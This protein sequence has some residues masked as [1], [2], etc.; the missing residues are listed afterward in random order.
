MKLIPIKI[1]LLKQGDNAVEELITAVQDNGFNIR[2]GDIL[3]IADKI[4]A[5]CDGR[6]VNLKNVTPSRKAFE[7]AKK[8]QLE[9][10]FVEL[11][12]KEA[13]EIYGGVPR[14][15][16]TL[17][18]N[19]LIANAG[20]DHKNVPHG[21]AALWPLNPN[22]SAKTLY[23]EIKKKTGKKIG[24]IL[25]DSHVNPLRMGTTGF[26]LGLA[27]FNPIKDCRGKLDLYGKPLRIT[28][29]NL[30]DD[31]AAA[32]HLLIGETNERTPL[33]IIR[34]APIELIEDYNPNQINIPK[35]ECLYM[36]NLFSGLTSE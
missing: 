2:N 12:L 10:P 11:V 27:G 20:I 17:K 31:L 14:A 3:A 23:E 18:H 7:L 34:G 26:A 4:I 35:E 19:F 22:E 28:R 16:L 15:I 6:I 30:V 36:K 13:D 8:Y 33:V 5:I 21:Y 9:P 32:A 24:I 25:V 29:V 1:R